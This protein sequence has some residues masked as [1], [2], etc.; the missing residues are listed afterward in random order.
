MRVV[1]RKRAEADLRQIVAWY[2]DVA[3]EAIPQILDDIY[4]KIDFLTRFPR[5]GAK[6]PGTPFHR[7][8][9]RRYHF[10][11]AYEFRGDTL[12][13]VGIFRFQDRKT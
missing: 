7:A 4:R 13:V 5:T 2:E 10:K 1:F 8:T 12:V 6:V 11:L 9:T 3:P